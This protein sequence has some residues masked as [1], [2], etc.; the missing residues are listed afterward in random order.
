MRPGRLEIP[1]GLDPARAQEWACGEFGVVV[2]ADEAG[3][4]PLFGPVA[5]AA[6]VLDPG[7]ELPGLDDSKKL[8]EAKREALFPLIQEKARAWGIGTA[9]AEEIDRMNILNAT[10]LAVRRALEQVAVPW[11][12][13]L[14]D[15]SVLVRGIDPARQFCVVKG[16]A[17]VQAIAAASVL[18]KVHRDR[19]I[20]ELAGKYPGYALERNKG[21][22]SREHLDGIRKLGYTPEHRRSFHVKELE[23]DLFGGEGA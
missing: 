1:E 10:F 6:V 16:D 4:G 13:L 19:L 20:V 22:P 12:R 8:T 9:S 5:A 18:A 15:G 14:M 11:D 7:T 23:P 17:R 21:Y 3:R 2:G